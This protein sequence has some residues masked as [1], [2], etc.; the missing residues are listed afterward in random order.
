MSGKGIAFYMY[1]G[2]G[3]HGCEA[4]ADSLLRMMPEE[5]I[6]LVSCNPQEDRDNIPGQLARLETERPIDRYPLQHVLYY[7]Y[8]KLTKDEESFLRFR[9]RSLTG[10]GAP[11]LAVSIGGDNYC[12]P[13]LFHDL[14]LANSMLNRQGTVTMLL[15]CSIEPSLFKEHPE[16]IADM[17]RYRL[18][19][20]RE[21]LT[22]QALRDQGISKEQVQL[23]PDPAFTL[24]V[25]EKPLPEGF[26]PGRTVG[27]NVSP[28]VTGYEKKQGMTMRSYEA[29][30][31]HIIDTTDLQIV[32]IPHVV[33]AANDDRVPL[34]QLYDQFADTGRVVL[35]QDAPAEV[36][37]GYI[38]RCRLFIGARTHATIAAY[39]TCVPTMVLGYS[40]KARGIAQDLFGTQEHYVLPVQDLQDPSQLTEGFDWLLQN[41]EPLRRQ[42]QEKMPAYK[43][44]A[45]E[46]GEAIRRLYQA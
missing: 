45:L 12:Y 39:S 33:W 6:R 1:A 29:L 44:K 17:K 24:P 15:G 30:L 9:F 14:Q 38:S 46:N 5:E 41:E 11:K 35:L 3:N 22:Y 2:S 36:L 32:L 16:L 13:T 28:M 26:V 37:K 7:G 19:L 8:R 18:I 25:M 31:Q 43:A 4:I 42:L 34:R 10:K 40:V 20:A 23:V 21:S 27:I